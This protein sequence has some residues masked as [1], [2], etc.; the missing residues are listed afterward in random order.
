MSLTITKRI[1]QLPS[2]PTL[3]K[4]ADQNSVSINGDECSGSF[5]LRGVAGNY[6]FGLGGIQGRFT[7]HG[8]T[9]KFSFVVGEVAVTITD[10]PL[11]LPAT[12]LK[13]KIAEG[14]DKLGDGLARPADDC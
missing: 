8:V 6:T 13:R 2:F 1:E 3:R 4:L 7:G 11:W 10:K 12:L 9:G 5:A 14:L